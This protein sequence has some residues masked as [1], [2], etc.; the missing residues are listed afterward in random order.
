MTMKES[1]VTGIVLSG[2]PLATTVEREIIMAAKDI[3]LGTDAPKRM[4]TASTYS[5][6]RS[7]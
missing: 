3:R 1:D 6:T 2:P 5:R 4:L 7:G